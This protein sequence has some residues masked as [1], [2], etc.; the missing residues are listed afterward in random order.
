MVR[1]AL[2][3]AAL[4]LS[5]TRD[6]VAQAA[7]SARYTDVVAGGDETCVLRGD[8]SVLCSGVVDRN[9]TGQGGVPAGRCGIWACDLKP[10]RIGF[11]A[12]LKNLTSVRCGPNA[13]G[14]MLCTSK[15][16]ETKSGEKNK[17][18]AY[19][20]GYGHSCLLEA[21]GGAYCRGASNKGQ[22]GIGGNKLSPE[23]NCT[24]G[25]RLEFTRVLGSQ[26]WTSLGAGGEFT[27]GLAD[28]KKVYCWGDGGNGRLGDGSG[29]GRDEPGAPVAGGRQF[30]QVSVGYQHACALSTTGTAYCWGR[31][32]EGQL[33]NGATADAKTPG[34][35]KG[36]LTFASILAGPLV[37][38]ALTEA[39]RAYCW[40][41]NKEGQLGNGQTAKTVLEPAAVAGDVTFARLATSGTHTCGITKDASA[42]YCWGKNNNGQFGTGAKGNSASP[43]RAMMQ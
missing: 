22:L 1:P 31:G 27:C 14:L 24:L 26:T 29:K 20:A 28:D 19:A 21:D 37:T 2:V 8:G 32:K 4:L 43:V 17:A 33:G 34:A 30:K 18:V 25:C 15:D 13:E 6:A 16:G 11:S 36:E 5:F 7:D 42:V 23:G 40:G 3:V 35:V 39:G 12:P 10:V 9:V 41:E 38:C